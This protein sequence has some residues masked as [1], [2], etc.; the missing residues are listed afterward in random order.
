MFFFLFLSKSWAKYSLIW[1][2]WIKIECWIIG[3]SPVHSL[4]IHVLPSTIT[5]AIF[6]WNL[7]HDFYVAQ[8]MTF[9]PKK[10]C[11]F[12]IG[13]AVID[14]TSNQNHTANSSN[15]FWEFQLQIS[16]F[17]PWKTIFYLY[18]FTMEKHLKTSSISKARYDEFR[19]VE[20]CHLTYQT[21]YT[22]TVH[23]T[24]FDTVFVWWRKNEMG[25]GG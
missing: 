24:L 8:C 13:V 6:A 9:K 20:Q 7:I 5:S 21:P 18:L 23:S 12:R 11:V 3:Y 22:Y 4:N 14:E 16:N 15:L 10:K 2:S 25:R 17:K 19:K 1:C